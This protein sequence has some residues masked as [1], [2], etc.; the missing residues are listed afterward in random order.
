MV[1]TGT[2]IIRTGLGLATAL[3]ATLV[4]AAPA[5]ASPLA[6]VAVDVT[7]P[8]KPYPSASEITPTAATI[9][10]PASWDDTAVAGYIIYHAKAGTGV[11]VQDGSTTL[12]SFRLTGL[13]PISPYQVRVRAYDAAGNISEY[14]T[15]VPFLTRTDVTPPTKPYPSPTKVTATT[16]TITWPASWDDVAVAGYRVEIASAGTGAYQEV[17]TTTATSFLVTGLT[18]ISPYQVRVRAYDAAGNISEYSTQIPFLTKV[19]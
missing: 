10:W 6:S 8:T 11:W 13:A 1:S 4:G 17:G 14:S 16:A 2:R 7:P 12:T 19:S 9:S 15:A 18:P 3:A 5:E